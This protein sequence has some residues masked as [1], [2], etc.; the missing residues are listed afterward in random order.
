MGACISTR[1]AGGVLS[2]VGPRHTEPRARTLGGQKPACVKKL[3]VDE[4]DEHILYAGSWDGL[5]RRYDVR[6]GALTL[7]YSG[8]MADIIDMAQATTAGGT[9]LLFAAPCGPPG[10]CC[11]R[12]DD[13][14]LLL[15]FATDMQSASPHGAF[16]AYGLVATSH[17]LFCGHAFRGVMSWPVSDALLREDGQTAAIINP[18]LFSA[19]APL[20]TERGA[21]TLI[22]SNGAMALALSPEGAPGR[23][24][25]V[26]GHIV[27]LGTLLSLPGSR[28][29]AVAPASSLSEAA[30][31][32]SRQHAGDFG[33]FVWDAER[34]DAVAVLGFKHH[35]ALRAVE[36]V[37]ADSIVSGD[38][39]GVLLQW[40]VSHRQCVR[41]LLTAQARCRV[42]L[43]SAPGGRGARPA[44]A[45]EEDPVL[46]SGSD[47]GAPLVAHAL[48][49]AVDVAAASGRARQTA[50]SSSALELLPPSSL[51]PTAAQNSLYSAAQTA[52]LLVTGHKAGEI[53]VWSRAT[54]SLLQAMAV[55]RLASDQDEVIARTL[56]ESQSSA[57]IAIVM[58]GDVAGS[59][60]AREMA[61]NRTR[62]SSSTTTSGSFLT[63]ST[64]A[65]AFL[66]GPLE[67]DEAPA[68][69]DAL[70]EA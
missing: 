3:L 43:F 40:C 58:P 64:T 14:Q 46:L 4:H 62:R 67:V 20:L 21:A 53:F 42:L 7:T 45:R 56:E 9:N 70:D 59:Y 19:S 11:W 41:Q 68:A 55:T 38:L 23:R 37:G 63:R 2:T 50:S 33:L 32:N 5:A 1:T 69:A 54:G 31:A 25:L 26:T 57:I 39:N 35:S 51:I 28:E 36:W 24:L 16:S 47:S 34:G 61:A 52:D 30:D 17:G 44:D 18:K 22:S 12:R 66:A 27:E 13:A 48:V 6:T 49:S 10:V 60:L 29:S 65:S 15:V 8:C